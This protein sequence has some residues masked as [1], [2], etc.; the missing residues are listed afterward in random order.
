MTRLRKPTVEDTCIES[1]EVAFQIP[2][3]LTPAHQWLLNSII[4]AIVRDPLNQ[5]EEG[6]HWLA[7]QGSKPTWSK[8][9]AEI[10]GFE[11][12]SDAH[13][14]GEPTFDNTTLYYGT[15]AR[16]FVSEEEKQKY[17]QRRQLKA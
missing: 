7:E 9:D 13:D 1:F 17:Q 16:E 4:S 11:T 15:C 14:E 6:V 5:F 12:T 2:V 10:F 3:Y 8:K